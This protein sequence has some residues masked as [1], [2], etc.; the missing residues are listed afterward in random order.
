M[1]KPS[2]E[3]TIEAQNPRESQ[4]RL[5]AIAQQIRVEVIKAVARAGAGHI[6]GPLSAAEI[7]AVLYFQEMR[8]RPDEPAWRERD[9]FVLSKGHS[10]IGLYA[11]LALRGY[12]PVE[13]L[14]TF[15]SINSRLQ[16]HPDMTRLP[17]IDMSTGSLGTGISAAVGLA[18]GAQRRS[19]PT[20]VYVLVGDG[21]CQEGEVWEAA[22][23]GQRYGLDNLVAVIDVNQLGQFGARGKS[24]D[25]RL[26]PWQDGE[27]ARRWVACGWNVIEADGHDPDSLLTALRQAREVT[28]VPTALLAHTTKGRG[29]SF[30]ENRWQWHS[31]VPTPDELATALVELEPAEA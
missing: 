15:D 28:G 24:A 29:V 12:F 22:F 13:E 4:D 19:L 20:R 2:R 7:L 26:P 23:V 11:A 3:S 1:T 18:M 30:M 6:G 17:G 16:G 25:I 31:R 21:E 5:L 10:S 8:V 9:R 14:A 27:L